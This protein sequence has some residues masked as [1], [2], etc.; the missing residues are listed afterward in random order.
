MHAFT[1]NRVV[2]HTGSLYPIL[3]SPMS[4]IARSGLVSAVSAAGATGMLETSSGLPIVQQEY[5]FI[6][7]R[8]DRPFGINIAIKF[9]KDRPEV[10]KAILD[11]A[12]DGRVSFMTT[13]AGDPRR[14]VRRIKDAG[15]TLYHQ[16]ASLDGALKAQDAGVDGLIVE[17]GESGGVRAPDSVHSFALLQ[18]VRE[19]TTLPLV[20]AGG[21]VD[22]RGMAAAF[23]LGAEGVAMGTRFVCSVESPVHDNYKNAIVDAATNDSMTVPMGPGGRA[24]IRVLRSPLSEAMARGEP[25]AA[26]A[27]NA[28]QALYVEGRLDLTFGSAGESAGLIHVVKPVRDIVD[29][30]VA[31]FW[32]EIE[33][34]AGLL[35]RRGEPAVV[36]A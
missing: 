20:A 31:G 24:V 34:L 17:G 22:G 5:E 30:A 10:E 28:I 35:D 14:H 27:A 4:W 32:R 2:G 13:S 36:G 11:W 3:Q 7:R 25:D 9:I 26:P 15:V 21:I 29:D 23:A 33:R 8:T 16:V 12:L 19:R 18:A 6:R 1:N